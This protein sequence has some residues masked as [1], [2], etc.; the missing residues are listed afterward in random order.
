M[1]ELKAGVIRTPHNEGMSFDGGSDH[2]SVEEGETEFYLKPEADEKIAMLKKKL[3]KQ[4]TLRVWAELQLRH[5]KYKRC[6]AMANWCFT[7]SNF[8]F[9]VGRS[10]GGRFAEERFRRSNLYLKWCDRWQRL[11]E[12]F[13]PQ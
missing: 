11:A 4:T 8:F 6:L 13:Q 5:N 1:N 9:V 7:R 12:T 10:E 3:V 2:I